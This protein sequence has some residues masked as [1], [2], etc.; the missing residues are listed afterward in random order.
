MWTGQREWKS[1]NL[2]QAEAYCHVM[3]LGGYSDWRLPTLDEVL[4]I[5][6]FSDVNPAE[7]SVHASANK[8]SA[9]IHTPSFPQSTLPFTVLT[10]KGGI[11]DPED[12]PLWTSS[13]VGDNEAWT[14][15]PG[16]GLFFIGSDGPN[17]WQRTAKLTSSRFAICTRTMEPTLLQI[18]KD[19]QVATPMPDLQTLEAY[20]PW[21]K[22]HA[23]YLAGQYQDAVADGQASLAVKAAFAPG[24][25][26][27]G[28]SYGRLGQW[29]QAVASL[30]A[31]LK[32]DKNYTPAKPALKWAQQGQKAAKSGKQPKD[33]APVWN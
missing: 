19:A 33:A 20:V 4:A 10:L 1:V 14:I 3:T 31:A 5:S 30:E 21:T 26:A 9:I 15:A 22:A 11:W 23:A 12:E 25:W 2:V 16:N 24:E 27:M 17:V 7:P 32:I 29:D 18:A 28:I 13:K 6:V 8:N